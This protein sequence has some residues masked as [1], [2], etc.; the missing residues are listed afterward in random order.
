LG[1]QFLGEDI[2]KRRVAGQ[3]K[4]IEEDRIATKPKADGG[5]ITT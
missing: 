2:P 1:V 4:K 3:T 5:L